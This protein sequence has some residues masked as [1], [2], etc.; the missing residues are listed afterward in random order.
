MHTLYVFTVPMEEKSAEN[1]MQAYLS[2]IFAHK[3]GSTAI[4]SDDKTE[5]KKYCTQCGMQPTC[6][7]ENIFK[8]ISPQRHL[9]N[10][11]VHS[12]SQ[13]NTYSIFRIQ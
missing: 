2:G 7:Q 5:L 9:R 6:N 13:E 4:L 3:G 12:I 8:P 1:V 11:N 10:E